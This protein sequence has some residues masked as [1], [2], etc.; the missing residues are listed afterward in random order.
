MNSE[1][2]I[3][4][5]TVNDQLSK[6]CMNNIV[7]GCNNILFLS[8]RQGKTNVCEYVLVLLLFDDLMSTPAE[9]SGDHYFGLFLI[10]RYCS[11][12]SEDKNANIYRQF[13]IFFFFLNGLDFCMIAYRQE[14]N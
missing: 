1:I 3:S 11:K 13:Y 8:N 6:C 12:T 10:R 14:L 2:L 7:T 5:S 9:P 4:I